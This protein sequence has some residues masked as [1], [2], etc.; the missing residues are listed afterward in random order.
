MRMTEYHV[1][2]WAVSQIAGFV[3]I[4]GF[5]LDRPIEG[6]GALEGAQGVEKIVE[7]LFPSLVPVP[8]QQRR[9]TAAPV[10]KGDLAGVAFRRGFSEIRPPNRP[11]QN[12]LQLIVL[13]SAGL[14]RGGRAA[15]SV[16][17]GIVTSELLLAASFS[18]SKS[19]C[20]LE[21]LAPPPRLQGENHGKRRLRFRFQQVDKAVL[22]LDVV[23]DRRHQLAAGRWFEQEFLADCQPA[24]NQPAEMPE[25]MIVDEVHV[26]H[27]IAVL[28]QDIADAIRLSMGDEFV[29]G[30]ASG[31]D[32]FPETPPDGREI[33]FNVVVARKDDKAVALGQESLQGIEDAGRAVDNAIQTVD[34]GL[35]GVVKSGPVRGDAV[36]SFGKKVDHI[37]I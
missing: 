25:H 17:F 1:A 35:F 12:L 37:P 13:C 31:S 4:D 10:Q 24:R 5:L 11:Y 18:R 33:Q 34:S 15:S 23:D 26:V 2:D 20:N 29:V 9:K 27:A 7:P 30:P 21:E 32:V 14:G 6:A 3:E 16:K 36:N 22:L 28:H 19:G 8:Q